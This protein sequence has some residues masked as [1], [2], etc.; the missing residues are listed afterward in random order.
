MFCYEMH[1]H[2][3]EVSMCGSSK[4]E[5]FVKKYAEL[6][7]AGI[8][9]TDHF[10][11]GNT[12][13]PR[14]LEWKKRMHAY[15]SPYEAA[16]RL[17]EILGIDVI[18][19]LE[20][21]YYNGKEVL[22]YGDITPET[23]AAHPEIDKMNIQ[24]FVGFCHENGWFV[25]Q[26]HPFRKRDYIDM[27]IPPIPELVDGIEVYNYF[28]TE[29]ENAKAEELCKQHSSIPISGSD[30]HNVA[31]CGNAGIAFNKRVSNGKELAKALF[32]NNFKLIVNGNV[33]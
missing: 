22:V 14:S 18:I 5:E 7:Y 1:L 6:G 20:H 25:A 13:I 10:I 12:A 26:A 3:S 30:A 29:D 11:H 31:H 8:V 19:G 4:P 21:A 23:L 2:C 33:V 24:E 15:F 27:S 17:G 9:F 32:E 28:N 16:K